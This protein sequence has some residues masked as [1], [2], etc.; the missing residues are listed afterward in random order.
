MIRNYFKVAVT[1]VVFLL[2]GAAL[3]AQKKVTT[4]AVINFDATTGL[5]PLPKAANTAAI[6]S[7]DTRTGNIAFE[8]TIKN[9]SF[10]NPRMQS[11]FNGKTWMDSN[12][13]PTSTFKGRITNLTEINFKADGKY[14]ARVEGSLT[15]HGV[16]QTIS[17]TANIVVAGKQIKTSS[18][19]S[20]KVKDYNISGPAIG[21]GKVATDPTVTVS[22]DFK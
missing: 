7:L 20:L 1:L 12:Q 8:V 19:F 9:F 16:T 21:A 11:D 18:Q 17:T 2:S 3:I 14:Q 10:A 6:G 15:I 4:S 13:F 5:N 22:A